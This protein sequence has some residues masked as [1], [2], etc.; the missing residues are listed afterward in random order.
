MSNKY[1]IL[2][3]FF[4]QSF[5][6]LSKPKNYGLSLIE[7]LRMSNSTGAKELITHND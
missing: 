4:L 6:Q 7:F 3:I 1:L 5:Y 2:E